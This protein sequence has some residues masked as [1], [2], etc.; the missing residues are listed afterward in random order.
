MASSRRRTRTASTPFDGAARPTGLAGDENTITVQIDGSENPAI[1]PFGELID[2]L[3][4]AGIYREVW[5]RITAPVFIGNLKIETPEVL[6]AQKRVQVTVEITNPQQL[7]LSG[8]VIAN[9]RDA[10]GAVLATTRGDVF[11]DKVQLE[12]S[13]LEGIAL[14]DLATPNLYTLDLVLETPHGGDEKTTRF[15]FRE[16]VFTPEGFRLNGR[17]LKLRGLNRHQSFPY[18]GY[19]LGRAAQERDA[20]ILKHE[21]HLNMVRTSHYPQSPWLPRSLRRAGA[22][23]VRGNPRLAAYRRQELARRSRC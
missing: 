19:A 21:L 3:T 18:S 15:G 4:Y 16:A 2:Y 9:L 20:D 13:N 7:A 5:L 22:P 1:P 11:G 10:T 6:A 14:W 17:P 12:L 23:G 8:A